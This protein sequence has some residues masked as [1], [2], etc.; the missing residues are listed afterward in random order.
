MPAPLF[1]PDSIS[2]APGDDVAIA[3]SS[4]TP[5]CTLRVKRV[6]K[7]DR[8]V[9]QLDLHIDD[10]PVPEEADRNGCGWSISG[11]FKV[12]SDWQTG[13][14]DL[15]LNA[16]DGESSHHFICV[17]KPDDGLKA[18]AVMI[19]ST[20]TYAAYNYWGGR[21]SYAHVE[22]LQRGEIEAPAAR[23]LALGELSWRRPLAQGQFAPPSG[24]PRL[25]ADVVREQ[26]GFPAPMGMDW[27]MENQPSSYDGSAGFLDKWEHKFVIW[28]EENGYDLDYVTDHDF[29]MSD[30]V[31]EGYSVALLVGHS[32]YWSA[33]G[34][35]QLDQFVEA[36]GNL[37]SL[38]GNTSYW[39]VRWENDGATMIAH[40][41]NG[42]KNDPLWGDSERGDEATHLWSHP[43]FNNPEASTFG[44]SFLYG[45]YHRLAM[46]VARGS[47]AFTVYNDEHWALEGSDLFYGDQL[48]A[49][50][51]LV[52][53]ENDGCPIRFG[54]DGLPVPDGGL[55]VPE[56][57]QII[58]FAPATLAESSRSVF[59]EMIPPEKT[60]QL[61]KIA[62]GNFNDSTQQKL[63]RGHAVM[64]TFTKGDGEVFNSGTTEWA[65]GLAAGDPFVEKITHNILARFGAER[66]VP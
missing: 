4:S 36:G 46:C 8:E 35:E 34:R 18:K 17:R 6:G 9:L 24:A 59:P 54:E 47:A 11:S 55:G 40:K 32:E 51:P 16:S 43:A 28:A 23:A 56:N 15:E 7:E 33:R 41:W 42:E 62:Y 1:Y 44:L 31:L 22:M 58:G 20:N 39:K 48:G 60:D 13:Y 63:M 64:A 5:N 30:N 25:I 21:N 37:A 38:S 66:K 2:V 14:Y 3:A 57:L 49:S 26:N 10:H 29:E 50:V 53:Y 61:A 45:G 19:L 27:I 52:G 65:H 12:G